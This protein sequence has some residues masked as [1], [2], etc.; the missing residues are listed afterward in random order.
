MTTNVHR[1]ETG[2]QPESSAQRDEERAELQQTAA[3]IVAQYD[4]VM[5]FA[6]DMYRM[7]R[8]IA[9]DPIR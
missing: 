1:L 4:D 6:I 7:A 9:G 8:M 5:H 3:R 2:Y